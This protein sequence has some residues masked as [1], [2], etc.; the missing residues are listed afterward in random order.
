MVP[1]SVDEFVRKM[2]KENKNIH[3]KEVKQNILSAAERKKKGT[4][5]INCGRPIWAI[6]SGMTGTDMCFSCTT[7]EADSSEDYEVDIV[8]Y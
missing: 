8:C 5:C 7:G 2:A 3:P 1:I 4:G 6:G